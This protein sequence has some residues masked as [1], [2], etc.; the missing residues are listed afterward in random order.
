[1]RLSKAVPMLAGATAV[2]GAV[3]WMVRFSRL[4]VEKP[5]HLALRKDGRFELREY[6]PLTVARTGMEEGRRDSAY[7]R[8]F[9][10]IH[11]GNDRGRNIAMTAPVIIDR[12]PGESTMN[13]VMP[14]QA[15]QEGVPAPTD[16]DVKVGV[17]PSRRVAV[18]RFSGT[19]SEANEQS[20]IDELRSWMA[21]EGL[22]PSGDPAVAYYDAPYLPP[23]LRRN[24]VMLTVAEA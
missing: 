7:L 9:G 6:P 4:S 23:F 22:R 11:R 14:E 18:Y 2:G 20:A 15:R 17:R 8:L 1:M 12:A 13:F 19:T 24:E 5:E 16:T 3:Y 10:F 21:R